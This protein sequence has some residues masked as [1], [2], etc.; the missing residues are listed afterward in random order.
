MKTTIGRLRLII[1]EAKIG[2]GTDYL[3]KEK[4]REAL[5]QMIVGL[6]ASGQLSDQ[7]SLDEAF[8]ALDMSVKALKMVPYEV[9]QRMTGVLSAAEPKTQRKKRG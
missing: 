6:V 5:Q 1:G 7:A 3:R 4:I 9:W 8:G 2:P